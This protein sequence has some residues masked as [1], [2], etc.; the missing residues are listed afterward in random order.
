MSFQE[1]VQGLKNA[2]DSLQ[3][4]AQLRSYLL[5]KDLQLVVT[6]CT[7]QV[8]FLDWDITR[9]KVCGILHLGMKVRIS[10][11]FSNDALL[12]TRTIAPISFDQVDWIDQGNLFETLKEGIKEC[13]K[14][15]C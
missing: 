5:E 3:S 8:S 15:V 7:S 1:D 12:E 10:R 6:I 13:I 11:A 9:R 2:L 14:K 4:V